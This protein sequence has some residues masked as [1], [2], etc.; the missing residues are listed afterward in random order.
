MPSTR[1]WH[2]PRSDGG[3]AQLRG[4][5]SAKPAAAAA[6]VLSDTDTFAIAEVAYVPPSAAD[7]AELD[8]LPPSSPAASLAQPRSPAAS[9]ARLPSPMPSTASAT[10]APLS[11][12][13]AP[14]VS[15]SAFVQKRSIGLFEDAEDALDGGE[16]R[17]AL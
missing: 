1:S 3:Q 5:A 8:L 17:D 15:E 9:A 7:A 13:S 6:A 16:Q 12:A 4:V 11:S 2:A 10:S 14:E